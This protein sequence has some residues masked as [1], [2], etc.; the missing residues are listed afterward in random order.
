MVIQTEYAELAQC[1]FPIWSSSP[2]PVEIPPNGTKDFV[3]GPF[4]GE[5]TQKAADGNFPH[6]IKFPVYQGQELVGLKA[7]QQLPGNGAN[8]S[9]AKVPILAVATEVSGQVDGKRVQ[10]HCVLPIWNDG[11]AVLVTLDW[12]EGEPS[13]GTPNP[14]YH[15]RATTGF[16]VAMGLEQLARASRL[17]EK[18]QDCLYHIYLTPWQLGGQI[19]KD[20]GAESPHR[21]WQRQ[22]EFTSQEE[23]S[24]ALSRITGG[25]VGT[26]PKAVA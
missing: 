20:K 2:I 12:F 9:L 14:E 6:I 7:F 4:S 22:W 24:K 13:E 3:V 17:S 18:A 5:I 1:D 26:D 8:Q 11:S 23:F 21:I 16:P 15:L 25:L 10:A 19:L